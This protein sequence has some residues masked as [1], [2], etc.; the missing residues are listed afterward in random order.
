[1]NVSVSVVSDKTIVLNK[2]LA[3]AKGGKPVRVKAVKGAHYLLAENGSG[4]GP[5]NITVKRVGKNLHVALE[6]SDPDQPEL[7]I[8]EF[9]GS[10]GQ[11]VG[12][13]EDG[14]Y[15]EYI[16]ADGDS[17]SAA[18]FLIDGMSSPLALGFPQLT[19]F[20]EGLV[21]AGGGA[22]LP[23]ALA[24]VKPTIDKIEDDVGF[25]RGPLSQ[26]QSTDDTTPTLSGKA[27]AGSTVRIYDGGSLLG[28]VTADPDGNW[29]F[30][31][32]PPLLNGAHDFAVTAED[33]A[34]NL[35]AKSDVFG[36][37]I[38]TVAPDAP[39][40]VSV[41][42]DQGNQTGLLNSG[43]ATDDTKPTL[44]GTAEPNSTVIVRDDSHEIGRAVAGP[45]GKWT[46]EPVLPMGLGEHKLTAEAVDAAGNVSAPS[47]PF[48]LI[49]GSPD[50]PSAP[51]ITSVIDDVGSITGNIQK[52]G[53]TDDAR[54]TINGTAQAGMTV[55]VYIDGVLAGTT[56]AKSNGDWSFTPSADLADGLHEIT[57]TATNTLGNISPETGKYPIV[58]D[59]TPPEVPAPADATLW[60]DAGTITGVITS[61]TITDDNTPTFNGVAEPN[62]TV[63]IYDDGEEIGRVVA[64]AGGAWSFTPSPVLVDG[65]HK[66]N[67]EVMDQAGNIGPKSETI[68]FTV[69]TSRLEVS[70]DGAIDDVG[71]ITGAISKGGVTDDTVPTLH[72]K[73]TPGGTVKIYEGGVLLGQVIAGN[74]GQWSMTLPEALAGGAHSL[75]ATVTT[76]ANGESDPSSAFDFNIDVTAP[77]IPTIVEVKDD[78]GFPQNALSKGESTDDTTPTLSG[79]AEAGS[80]VHVYDKG[81]L[82]GSVVARESGDWSFTPSPPLLNGVHEFTVKAEDKAGNISQPSDMF[83]IVIDTVA[84]EKPLIDSVYDD[85]GARTGNV[86]AGASTDDARPRI[87]GSAEAGSTVIIRDGDAELGRVIAGSDGKWVFDPPAALSEGEHVLSVEA[88]DAAGNVSAPSD[89]FG[90]VVDTSLPTAPKILNITDDVGSFKGLI[91]N[92]GS[93]DDAKPTINGNGKAGETIEIYLDGALLGTTVVGE[94][95][96][97]A[98]TPEVAL[99]DGHYGLTALAVSAGGAESAASNLFQVNVDTV[100][101]DRPVVEDVLDNAGTWMGSLQNG[102]VTDDRTPTFK[103]K[104]E[105]GTTIL[106]FDHGDEI[107]FASVG[108]DGSWSYSTEVLGFGEHKITFHSVDVAANLSPASEAWVLVVT[109]PSRSLGAEAVAET[110]L[111][112]AGLLL[113][114]YADIFAEDAGQLEVA[115]SSEPV[116]DLSA[117]GDVGEQE[118]WTVS[119]N[120]LE[121]R[122]DWS[123]AGMMDASQML[124]QQ[125][126]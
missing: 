118:S 83:D 32:S 11:L 87:S 31:P 120:P 125:L 9:F 113:D 68:E 17:D 5:E 4:V 7:I 48:D 71:G 16:A 94:N 45:D 96:R 47:N 78:V 41:V 44:S 117:A 50:Q 14:L 65:A 86:L 23:W 108:A 104:A 33:K 42:D 46:L 58:V 43:D 89:E 70:I 115:A 112:M 55:S 18:A 97:W 105:P 67:Y 40:I 28:A 123:V 26:G 54:P 27:E 53:L 34:G 69:D 39:V 25:P 10:G 77:D 95:G 100:A 88:M 116:G 3:D 122:T 35:S 37:V 85:Q 107:G 101:P 66:L 22:M 81:S 52:D 73:A 20:A 56:I 63:I 6:G 106:V 12:Q 51:A 126:S 75:T 36:I 92:G 111:P 119:I 102:A 15:H 99:V 79:K 90:F 29:N 114:G 74:D 103:G 110:M 109:M 62:A 24:G 1:M 2:P 59:T 8:E 30:T 91:K 21:L 93:T 76:V 61:G 82:L 64:N 98:F 49:L 121:V 38:D 84:P 19:G 57:A 80:T 72:G 124:D 13:G 60:D